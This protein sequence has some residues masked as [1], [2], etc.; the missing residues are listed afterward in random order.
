MRNIA[1]YF[2][3]FGVPITIDSSERSLYVWKMIDIPQLRY[4]SAE[5]IET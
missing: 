4:F 1:S 3:S 5:L 2:L